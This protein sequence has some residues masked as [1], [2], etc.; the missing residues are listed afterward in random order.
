[1]LTKDLLE[2]TKRKPNITPQYRDLDEYRPAAEQ[3]IE[4]YEPGRTRA[5]IEAAV[6]DLETHDTFKLVRGLSKLLDRRSEFEHRAPEPPQR[7]REAVFER[8]FVTD[9]SE[10]GTVIEQVARDHDLEAA[11][12]ETSLWAD[13][14]SEAV[15]VT[16]PEIGPLELLQQYNLSLTQTLLFDAQELEFTASDNYQEIFGLIGYLGLMYRVD[17]DLAV[18]VTGPASLFSKTRKYGTTL[19]K[20]IP[21]IMKAEEWSITAQVE[22]EVS[23]ET[24]IYEFDLDDSQES[25]FP[26]R[27]AVDSFDSEVERDFATR[28][29]SLA[30]GWTVEREP[31]ILRTG[32]SVMI[33]DF[34]F[35]RE[36]FAEGEPAFY[37]EVVGF[38]TPEYLAE[39]LEKVRIVESEHPLMLAVN[40]T[41]NCTEGDFEE[42]NAD[43]VFFYDDQ[44]PVRPV[45]SRLNAI[46]EQ[47]VQRDLEQLRSKGLEVPDD[48][49]V[50]LEEL[51]AE[52]QMEPA[53]VERYIQ[54]QDGNTGI[55]SNARYAPPAVLEAIEDAVDGLESPTLADVNPILD[56]YGLAQ[57]ALEALGYTIAY[58]TLDQTEA[59][60]T[61]DG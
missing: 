29:N 37:L 3:V 44:I 23:D 27:T 17:D 59:T 16:P 21:A 7:L 47:H 33:P 41:L 12:V 43:A 6:S 5:E 32:T 31:T 53:A 14:E 39:K 2:V 54:E 42:T 38:W 11:A 28:I 36:R 52:H 15:L 30:D 49:V 45:V 61:K 22:T 58:Q 50:S 26:E 25:L 34:A 35:T 19:A 51:A 13:R 46:D 40:E 20:L 18:T 48:R 9:D 1:M 55:I 4:T 60:L 8:G 57:N 56:R 10:R 24:R